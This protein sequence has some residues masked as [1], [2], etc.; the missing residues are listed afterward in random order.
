MRA[1]SNLER[2]SWG[3]HANPDTGVR[4]LWFV[5]VVASGG[6]KRRILRVVPLGLGKENFRMVDPDGHCGKE[7]FHQ[8]KHT[9][10]LPA[11]HPGE[12]RCFLCGTKFVG[13]EKR[14]DE[15]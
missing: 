13:F 6:P 4:Y 7:S 2:G 3:V 10:G 1:R 5:D 12:C 8:P 15:A 9:C 11:G 14:G